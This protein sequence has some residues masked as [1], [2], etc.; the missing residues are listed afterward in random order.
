M[1]QF[2]AKPIPSRTVSPPAARPACRTV[3]ISRMADDIRELAFAGQN[4]SDET[5]KQRGWSEPIIDAFFPDAEKMAR[6]QSVRQIRETE[7]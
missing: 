6:R 3:L 4:V 5:L 1:I 7:L 2:A